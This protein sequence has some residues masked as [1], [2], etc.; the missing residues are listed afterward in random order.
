MA[1]TTCRICGKAFE[2]TK[3]D[4]NKP[5]NQCKGSDRLCKTCFIDYMCKK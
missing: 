5:L 4:A 2:T 3:A 1:T